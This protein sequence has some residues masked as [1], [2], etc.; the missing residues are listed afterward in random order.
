MPILAKILSF[1]VHCLLVIWLT[2]L[3]LIDRKLL[4]ITFD[5]FLPRVQISLTSCLLPVPLLCFSSLPQ[6]VAS[7]FWGKAE[8]AFEQGGGRVCLRPQPHMLVFVVCRSLMSSFPLV[9]FFLLH[10]PLSAPHTHSHSNTVLLMTLP[11]PPLYK[12]PC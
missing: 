10:Q 11:G 9:F 4:I 1:H 2:E 12:W 3:G 7:G 8:M 5:Y 6:T